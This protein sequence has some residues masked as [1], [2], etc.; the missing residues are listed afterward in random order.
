MNK[1]Q[2][3]H[4]KKIKEKLADREYRIG[5]DLG[6]GS[7]GYAIV[8]LN[9][10][11][12]NVHMP[13]DIIL[14]GSRIFKSSI[15]AAER[16]NSRSQRNTHRHH[17]E[18]MRFLWKLLAEK[19]LALPLL[20]NLD[21]KENSIK[22]ET[23][24]K[25][26]PVD[27]LKN[28]PYT[29]RYK[30]LS[31]KLSLFEL[32]YVL[33]HI[34]NH[35]GTASVRTF[36]EDDEVKKKE[37]TES[38]KLAETVKKDMKSKSYRT[39]GEYLYKESIH[40][41]DKNNREKVTNRKTRKNDKKEFCVTRDLIS[42]E[43]EEILSI[44]KKWH[45]DILTD[46]FIEKIKKAILYETKKLIPESSGCCPYF[47]E[48]RLPRSHKLNEYR[49]MYE[50]LNNAR[51]RVPEC[52]EKTG[53]ILSYKEESFSPEQKNKLFDFLLEGKE[54]TDYKVREILENLPDEAE[55]QL[56]GK[57]KKTQKIKGYVLSTLEK[58][59]FWS[60]L[61]L[62]QDE[63][64]Q[65]NFLYDWNSSP[66]EKTLRQKLKNE[67][68]LKEEEI[69]KAFK[70]IVL[71]SSY[72]PVGKKAMKILLDYI[73]DGLSYN[74]AV[75]KAIEEK[76]LPIDR[77]AEEK[78]LPIDREAFDLLPYYGKIL[79][80]DTQMPIGKAFSKQ[81][82]DKNYKKPNTNKDEMYSGRIAN[83]VVHQ[84]LN[85]LRKLVN[86]IIF[87]FDKKKP[88]EIGLEIARELKKSQKER[89]KIIKQQKKNEENKD[90][91]YEKYIKP[92][93]GQIDSRQE[94]IREYVK[95][96]E[97][98][99]EQKFEEKFIC[100]FCTKEISIDDVIS[101]KVDIEHI[102]PIKDSEDNSKN[103]LCIAHNECNAD[104]AK[105]PPFNAFGHKTE[106]KYIWNNI[107]SNA[108]KN[109]RIKKHG[110]FIKVLLKNF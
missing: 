34:A 69:D 99:E 23:S 35:R 67:Y 49:R 82:A 9:K 7:I 70:E 56:Q 62:Q 64:Q 40:E 66:D 86:E 89:E 52:D 90:K 77:E 98:L 93:L 91:I 43:V 65:D 21:K 63:L 73:K 74:E 51:Y 53:E 12:D 94:N 48:K 97:L 44:Q 10:H 60:R 1:I 68:K 95:K 31:E 101:S 17:R 39:Y 19:N 103:N 59:S 29:L 36:L 92:H 13:E 26:F 18:R 11:D 71:P 46:D 6:V 104:K 85:E 100:P 50:A 4:Y 22:G 84:T 45:N 54:L 20:Q 25:R 37:Q 109:H 42:K 78:K 57:D 5:L 105:R 102:F 14:A 24:Q 8:S 106:G 15:G 80:E 75:D 110:V 79:K 41:K 16:K 61:E 81:F 27:T 2:E 107:L 87:I 33:Y 55:I 108:E 3:D 28:D 32:G 30:A 88:L 83:P 38:A 96:F 58:S 72:A 76:K 47:K